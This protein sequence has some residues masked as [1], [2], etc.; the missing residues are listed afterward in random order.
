[1]FFFSVVFCSVCGGFDAIRINRKFVFVY[2]PN[3]RQTLRQD[4]LTYLYSYEFHNN[5]VLAV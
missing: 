2:F 5:N 4:E 1:M 3:D